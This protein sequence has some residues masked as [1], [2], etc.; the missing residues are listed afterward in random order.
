MSLLGRIF[1]TESAI[2]KIADTAAEQIDTLYYSEQERSEDAFRAREQ[3]VGQI[4]EWMRATQGERIS[5]RFI[6]T[7]IV[8]MWSAMWTGT[9][10]CLLSAVW[11][12]DEDTHARI[13]E[14]ANLLGG[15]ASE[16]SAE[17]LLILGY[18]FAAPQL[19]RFVSPIAE[20]MRRRD[21]SPVAPAPAPTPPARR[22]EHVH[23]LESER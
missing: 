3:A 19:D 6:A 13:V 10:I 17:V 20:R 11:V 9:A 8:A 21:P 7:L 22:P 5:R 15:F 4:V 12:A 18:Y 2:K 16:I 1:G 23:H 14:T